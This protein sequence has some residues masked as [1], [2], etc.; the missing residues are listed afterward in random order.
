MATIQLPGLVSGIDTQSIIDKMMKA[1]QA[2]LLRLQNARDKLDLQKTHFQS[3]HDQ[4]DTF[5]KNL[6]DL[7]MQS[8]FQ[9]KTTTS[10]DQ[11]SV[12]AVASVSAVAGIHSISITEVAQSAMVTSLY[13]K[14]SLATSPANTAGI[15]SVSGSPSENLEGTNQ[16][17]IQNMTSY[18]RAVSSF[19]RKSG[20][21]LA[22]L[23]GSASGVE[24]ATVEGAIA[25]G[26]N[27]GAGNNQLAMT[28]DGHAITVTLA[29]AVADK[30]SMASVAADT[31]S[32]VNAALNTAYGTE[33]VTYVAVRTTRNASG[34]GNDNFAFYDVNSGKNNTLSINTG[35]STAHTALGFTTG[36]TADFATHMDTVV[37][38]TNLAALLGNMNDTTK[39]LIPGLHFTAASGGLT[40][41]TASVNTSASLNA[42]G[43]TYSR[44]NGAT[45]V[46]AS[47]ILNVNVAGLQSAG[48]AGDAGPSTNGT[49]TI[50]GVQITVGD[51]QTL[52]VNDLLATINGSG[53]GVVAS[54]DSTTD[55]FNLQSNQTG[56][57]PITL[58]STSDTSNFLTVA[59][60][61]SN[62]GATLV[63][64]A[65]GGS[66]DTTASL[67][68]A[69]L[70]ITPTSGNFTVNGIKIYV[71]TAQ[72]TMESL[73]TKIN[74][75]GAKATARYDAS[76]GHFTIQ[77]D[78]SEVDT[79][80]QRITLG[81]W[82]D[83][84]NIL[85]AMNL[86]G[87]EY[88]SVSGTASS[89]ARAAD[90]ITFTNAAGASTNIPLPAIN[91]TGGYQASA[92]AVNW[93]D[94]IA[95]GAAYTV[96]VGGVP[97]TWTNNTGSA[98][99]DID[100]FV[101]AW[102]NSSYWSG[103][104]QNV[105]VIKEGSDS[106]RFFSLTEGQDFTVDDNGGGNLDDLYELGLAPNPTTQA[107]SSTNANAGAP[108]APYN[109]IRFAYAVNTR[110]VA[111]HVST[112]DAGGI[113][114]TSTNIGYDGQFTLTENGGTT[115]ADYFG[116]STVNAE[117]VN[118]PETGIAGH[119]ARFTVDGFSY[120][121]TS[122]TVSDV[123]NGVTLTLRNA[124]DG[125]ATIS[126]DND[127][128]KALDKLTD[129][130]VQYNKILKLLNPPV[131][132]KD[133]RKYLEPL[134]DEKKNSMIY[135]D[136]LTYQEKYD[137]YN[138]Y[139]DIR[140][141]STLSRLFSSVR[142]YAGRSVTGITGQLKTLA[143]LGITPG[144]VGGWDDAKAGYLIEAPSGTDDE[145]RTAVRSEL[146]LNSTLM[147]NLRDHADQV[148]E[149]FGVD[150]TPGQASPGTGLAR[151]LGYLANSYIQPGG[152][153]QKKIQVGGTID[154]QLLDMD[155]RITNEEDRLTELQERYT[156]QFAAMENAIAKLNS[157]TSSISQLGGSST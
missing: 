94:G 99:N 114:V 53:A 115:I 144:S 126:I 35:T 6:L 96:T 142:S 128:S 63:N 44:L 145:Y 7:R 64:G 21:V 28:Y 86:V 29:D 70:T 111:L 2:P 40:V 104:A 45:G 34:T 85:S 141:E 105:G 25:T 3:V 22:T 91:T 83:T 58:G 81:D 65:Q 155:D 38:A 76:S 154:T 136:I 73:I 41:G 151:A 90:S 106:L 116:S 110:E 57:H 61:T 69:G 27:A 107:F 4:I 19:Q 103:G 125:S 14:P 10:T 112:T 8:T 134:T 51:Y 108:S 47:G 62:T 130:V 123:I 124:T 127:T 139:E 109:A 46:A 5:K 131:L 9:S 157:Q 153:L 17:S 23:T 39:G 71:D 119:D 121:R 78:T 117:L 120:T 56:Y 55:S 37:T 31:Q 156:R 48:F 68:G 137:L 26:I 18:Y 100:T 84:S 36:G 147:D 20:G 59:K 67:Q 150:P 66:I 88:S 12:T 118:Q 98:L 152:L 11:N 79:N 16:L 32:K 122:N 148:F 87:T 13:A 50:N 92:G 101:S 72:D 15:V 80:T 49:F 77:S 95:A 89:A 43:A 93:K 140:G 132:T 133:Q 54:Y 82:S 97:V 129:F 113:T 74:N 149:L 143:D 102:N 33:D 138:S 1:A 135:D 60:L 146:E 75:S 24:S 30:T 42:T 52:S